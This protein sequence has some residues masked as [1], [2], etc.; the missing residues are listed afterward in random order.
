MT[1]SAVRI[2]TDRKIDFEGLMILDLA[3]NHQGSVEHGRRIIRETAAVIRSAGVRGAIKLQFRDLD[4]FIHPDFKN[5]TENKHIP[6]F[7]STRLS[8]DQFRELVEETRRQGMI[9]I[10]TPFDEASVDML[11]RLGVEI[12]KVASCSAGDWPLLDRI[13]ETGKPVIC[14]TAGLEISEVDRIVSFF[15]HRGVHFA[16]MHCVAMYPT[17]NNRLDLNRIE[18]FR[19]RYPGVTVGFSTHEDP[20]NF[21]IVGVA[22]ARGARL[23]E[24]HVG[25]PTEEIKLNAYSAS[26][27]QVASWIAA[28]QT[29]VGACGGE[30]LALRDAEEVS[31]LRALMRG[32]FLRKDAPSAT[33]LDRSDIY[34]AVPLHADQL[35]SGEWKDGTTADRDYRAG[36]PLRAAAR[37]P[38]DPRRQIIYGAI[39]AAKG[40][41]NEAR[42]PVGV[43]FN[44]ELSHHYGVE[45]FR[46]VGVMI[47]DCINREYC[48]KLLVQLPGQ[49]HP[50]HYHKKKEETFQMLSGV[51]ELEIEGFRKTLYAGDT[52]V[53]PR[54]VWHRFWTDTGAVFEEVST[55]HFN[56]DSF[57]EDRTVA[58]MPREDR[59]TRL[60]NWGRHQ[61]D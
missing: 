8:E 49:R 29:A 32:V 47:I 3:N 45:N 4:T 31:Q 39:H 11:E 37:V 25:V 18:I 10:A 15:Q 41:L 36:E 17:P 14:S 58:R 53:V 52:L 60:V 34:F 46:E 51:L 56:D 12:V 19:N 48:K 59:K 57:Y 35:T 28:Y 20:G 42:I 61:F 38:A 24:K 21:Q 1:P 54:G 50:S 40:M 16:L 5:S 30:K 27:E 33:R 55:T 22:Y 7:L 26:P 9:T 23:F 6:R 2:P 43:E 44:V 13:S